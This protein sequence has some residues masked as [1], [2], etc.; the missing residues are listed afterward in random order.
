MG[1]V[2]TGLRFPR[3]GAASKLWTAPL[4]GHFHCGFGNRCS[5][6]S[7]RLCCAK[8]VHRPGHLVKASGL[9]L[10]DRSGSD[11]GI[12]ESSFDH[13]WDTESWLYPDNRQ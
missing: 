1:V 9:L 12:S 3:H 11:D 2:L 4:E 8:P 10:I 13:H 5:D 7:L 6:H